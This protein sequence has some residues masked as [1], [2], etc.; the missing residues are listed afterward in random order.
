M[1][2]CEFYIGK[3]EDFESFGKVLERGTGPHPPKAVEDRIVKQ[4]QVERTP[5][6]AV[7]DY[8]PLGYSV[9]RGE[10]G[11]AKMM[12]PHCSEVTLGDCFGLTP[13]HTAAMKG[14]LEVV[15]MLEK[16]GASLDAA[17]QH[18]QSPLEMAK[19]NGNREIVNYLEGAC[20]IERCQVGD[21]T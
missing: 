1:N 9:I 2:D 6:N 18:G 4:Y 15:V 5:S 10:C 12:I 13:L 3:L 19:V 21:F 17:N 16:K 11:M 7:P 8:T 14:Y 20:F